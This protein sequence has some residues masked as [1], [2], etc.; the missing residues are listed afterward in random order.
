MA[1]FKRVYIDSLTGVYNRAFLDEKIA[2]ILQN[3]RDEGK[4]LSVVMFD[5]DYFKR[6][7]D[8]YGHAVGDQV[9]REFAEF[10]KN[11]LRAGD[12][13]IRYGG[14][15]FLAILSNVGYSDALEDC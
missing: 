9:L 1:S 5:I 14:D 8:L 3:A 13:L 4:V 7:N 2:E 10:L 15:E 11:S 6:I 12:I